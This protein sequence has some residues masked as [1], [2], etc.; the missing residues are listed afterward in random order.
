MSEKH[1]RPLGES[2][3]WPR[4]DSSSAV[5]NG[6]ISEYKMRLPQSGCFLFCF[7]CNTKQNILY[8]CLIKMQQLFMA[9]HFPLIYWGRF[10]KE[11][12]F[13]ASSFAYTFTHRAAGPVVPGLGNISGL[14]ALQ[15]NR[16]AHTHRKKSCRSEVSHLCPTAQPA[17]RTD[18]LPHSNTFPLYGIKHNQYLICSSHLSGQA[19]CLFLL[20]LLFPFC[21]FDLLHSLSLMTNPNY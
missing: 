12:C 17:P 4:S 9:V 21:L 8:R 3:R 15:Y 1:L 18:L 6:L 7:V 19:W 2:K 5:Q 11:P 13:I 14:N 20:L 16:A 10:F